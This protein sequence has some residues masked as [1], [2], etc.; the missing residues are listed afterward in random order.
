[1]KKVIKKDFRDYLKGLSEKEKAAIRDQ[2]LKVTG[3]SY[4][5]WY[6]KV[7]GNGNFSRKDLVVLGNICNMNFVED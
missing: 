2:F 4:P 1:M 7:S 5:T 3:L 6:G